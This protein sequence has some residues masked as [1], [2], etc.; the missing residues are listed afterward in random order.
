MAGLS[1]V[2]ALTISDENA[3]DAD[4]LVTTARPNTGATMANTTF[5]GGAARNVTVTTAGTSDNG[6]TNTIVGTDVFGNALTEVITST[7]SAEAVAGESL[8]LTVTSVTSSAQFAGNITVGSGSLCAQAVESSNRVRI[9]G[10]SV[11]S[12]GTAGD[13]EFINGTP[14][15]GTTLFKS[16]TIGTANTTIDRSIPSEGVLFENGGCVKYTVDVADNITIFYA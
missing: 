14:E 9:K 5:A 3:A 16:R 6:K 2:R 4:R 12:G 10:M 7:G 11:V 1:D 13:V 8:F 15:S